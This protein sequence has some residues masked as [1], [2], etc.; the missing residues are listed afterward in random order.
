MNLSLKQTVLAAG[1]VVVALATAAV[2]TALASRHHG[3]LAGEAARR[4][5]ASYLLADEL[6]QSSD[7]LTRLART[8]VVSGGDPRWE[9]Q[10]LEI[11]DIRNGLKPRPRAY[12][13][14]YWDFRA[15]D[16][17]VP[18]GGEAIAL[19]DLMKREGFSDQELAKLAEAKAN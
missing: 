5:H 15:V 16:A 10:Y 1:A 2:A 9:Q 6:R 8:Y 3:D 18:P 17:D 7:D 4:R 19:L 14:I 12:E 13:R 11:L